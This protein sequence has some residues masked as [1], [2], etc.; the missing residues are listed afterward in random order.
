M[1]IRSYQEMLLWQPP[2][3]K[4]IV[5][6][7]ILY[8]QTKMVLFGGPKL[9]KSI[10]A[11]QLSFCLSIGIPWLGYNT[12]PSKVLYVQSEISERLFKDRVESMGQTLR[13][14]Q[15]PPQNLLFSTITGFHLDHSTASQQLHQVVAKHQPQVLILDPK[16]K[17]VSSNDENAIVR[18]TD[19]VDS[20]IHNYQ[21][22]VVVIDHSRKPKM[23]S[24]GSII[25]MGG[26]ELRG[27]IVEQW[28]D[29]IIRLRGDL[30][31]DLRIIDF[32]LRHAVRFLRPKQILLQRQPLWF[33]EV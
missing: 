13:L 6:D 14:V 31:S 28:A 4:E 22:A 17:L 16:Y 11:Q 30:S 5:S 7:G 26:F 19:T 3:M 29:G 10:L 2:P 33:V 8:E 21:I 25:D 32:E 27:P 9:G 24:T 20:L 1:K 15:I 18:F 12:Q 23:A